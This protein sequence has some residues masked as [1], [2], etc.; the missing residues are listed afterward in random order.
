MIKTKQVIELLS[1]FPTWLQNLDKKDYSML[2]KSSIKD[3]IVA[4]NFDIKTLEN[5]Q[6]RNEAIQKSK[7]K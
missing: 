2:A 1:E 6:S 7:R 4:M 5:I 3:Y